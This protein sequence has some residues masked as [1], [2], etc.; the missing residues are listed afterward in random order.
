M[1]QNQPQNLTSPNTRNTDQM[2]HRIGSKRNSNNLQYQFGFRNSRS[3]FSMEQHWFRFHSRYLNTGL[4]IRLFRAIR[5]I[6]K[7]TIHQNIS[8][9]I[10]EPS[11][12]QVKCCVEEASVKKELSWRCY[13]ATTTTHQSSITRHCRTTKRAWQTFFL[14]SQSPFFH[15]Y[16][17][18]SFDI[19]VFT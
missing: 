19:L 9:S 7:L 8:V 6:R 17:L 18:Y 14:S 4:V 3:I 5:R 10:V 12:F 11:K 16:K 1:C 2:L 15:I 13:N